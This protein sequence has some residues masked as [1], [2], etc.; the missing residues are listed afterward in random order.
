MATGTLQTVIVCAPSAETMS[1]CPAGSAP[2]P[3]SAYVV[4]PESASLFDAAVGPYN[5]EGAAQFFATGFV[6]ILT[7]Y[8]GSRVF[9][10]L[11]DMVRRS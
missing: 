8:F 4:S 9:G 6:F 7:L 3:V 5:Y 1:P 10:M 11:L 2:A